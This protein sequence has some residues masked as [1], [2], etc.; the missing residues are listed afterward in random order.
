MTIELLVALLHHLLRPLLQQTQAQTSVL[1][2]RLLWV[3]RG[4]QLLLQQ[5][6]MLLLLLSLQD[7]KA[8][9]AVLLLLMNVV[10]LVQC[11]T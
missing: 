1:V 6:P 9:A 5:G 2:P 10:V 11:C 8:A 3:L 7:I 4:E